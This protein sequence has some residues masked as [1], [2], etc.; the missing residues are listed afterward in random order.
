MR[1]LIKLRLKFFKRNSTHGNLSWSLDWKAEREW[2]NL[3]AFFRSFVGFQLGFPGVEITDIGVQTPNQPANQISTFWTKSDVDLSRGL[4]FTPRGKIL[5]RFTH[6]NHADYTYRI[7]ANNR[8]NAPRRGTVRIFIAPKQDERGLP[9]V[10]RDQKELMIE[11]DKFTVLRKSPIV[12][13]IFI[14]LMISCY[15]MWFN[16]FKAISLLY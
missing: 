7:V 11:M 2:R 15:L 3:I 12:L 9:Y 4:D 5:A 14:P 6:L 16:T 10:F 8:N 1:I 13:I